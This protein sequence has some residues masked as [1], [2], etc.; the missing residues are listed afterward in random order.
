MFQG[1][2][3][4]LITP[5][6]E[7]GSIDYPSLERLINFQLQA[8]IQGFV[9]CG[10]TGEK[11]TLHPDEEWAVLDFICEKTQGKTQIIFNS[12]SNST[13]K[14]IQASQKASHW[15]I[16]GL[17]AVV[18]FYN[19]PDPRGLKAHFE[20]IAQESPKPLILYNVPSRTG[21]ELPPSV[22]IELAKHP[23]IVGIKEAHPDPR[24]FLKYKAHLPPDFT[25]LSGDDEN[26]IEF[27]LLGGHGVI[28]VCSHLAPKSM[29][30]WIQRACQ[31][32]TSVREDFSAHKRWIQHLYLATNPVGVKEVLAER[33]VISSKN[34]RLPLVPM[35][36]DLRN[37][38]L[39]VFKKMG[40]L[41]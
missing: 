23:N 41:K 22:V 16:D 25:C 5:F 21:I 9:V 2:F 28:S 17:L 1:T 39:T 33:G 27:C 14:T 10:T 35:D 6:K 32:E 12:G 36:D 31:K 29:V 8:G 26:S 18:P 37:K 15:P 7:G 40:E 24:Q 11:P 30:N 20:K 34:L 3:T 38:V 19:K 4:A 13:E